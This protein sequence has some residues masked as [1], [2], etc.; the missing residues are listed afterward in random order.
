MSAR[1]ETCRV[2]SCLPGL[3]H[4]AC[5]G[6]IPDCRIVGVSLEDLDR[7]GF[8]HHVAR[9]A[10]DQFAMRPVGEADWA[11]FAAQA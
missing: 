9:G 11:N 10:L 6:F 7:D 1:R 2:A 4:L 5:S 3:F 8:Q